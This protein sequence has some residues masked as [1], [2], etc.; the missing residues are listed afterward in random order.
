[1]EPEVSNWHYLLILLSCFGVYRLLLFLYAWGFRNG[2][3]FVIKKQE[4]HNAN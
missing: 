2:V 4:D 3:R 1:M